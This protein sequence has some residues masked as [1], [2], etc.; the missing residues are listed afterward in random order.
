MSISGTRSTRSKYVRLY[1]SFRRADALACTAQ[2]APT[3]ISARDKAQ[4]HDPDLRPE[5]FYSWAVACVL[6]V[7]ALILRF[8]NI[9]YPDQVV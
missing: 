6:F 8:W 7:L 3:W 4:A 5:Y 9:G 1:C 2:N